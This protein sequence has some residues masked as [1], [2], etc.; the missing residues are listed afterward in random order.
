MYGK[1]GSA[2]SGWPMHDDKMASAQ[3]KISGSQNRK[4][5]WKSGLRSI[6]T[7]WVGKQPPLY[8]DPDVLVRDQQQK[9][10]LADSRKALARTHKLREQYKSKDKTHKWGL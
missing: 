10:L 4:A 5:S 9:E 1:G 8:H 2:I 6:S 3:P 7:A